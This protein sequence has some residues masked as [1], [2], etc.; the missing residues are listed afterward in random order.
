MFQSVIVC[1]NTFYF[2][3]F[4]RILKK[5]SLSL[6]MS[7]CEEDGQLG[8][9]AKNPNSPPN[10]KD[11][12]TVAHSNNLKMFSNYSHRRIYH[13][14]N[15]WPYSEMLF[16]KLLHIRTET[17]LMTWNSKAP[18]HE[19]NYVRNLPF[20]KIRN[21][22]KFRHNIQVSPCRKRQFLPESH[23][24]VNSARLSYSDLLCCVPQNWYLES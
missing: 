2:D 18:A 21:K 5:L 6:K 19:E 23:L 15:Y 9:R 11:Q 14:L 1:K 13:K 4:F 8:G 20:H 22:D 16:L 12:N 7:D 24:F 17:N 10:A 3:F